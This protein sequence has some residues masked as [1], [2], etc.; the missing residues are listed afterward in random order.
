MDYFISILIRELTRDKFIDLVRQLEGFGTV[1]DQTEK[2]TIIGRSR[3]INI[4]ACFLKLKGQYPEARFGISQYIGLAKGLA[5]IAKFGEILISEEIEQ[6]VIESY[7]ITSLGMLTIEGMKSQILV[8]RIDDPSRDLKYPERAPAEEMIPRKSEVDALKNLLTVT[9]AVLVIAP[10]GSGKTCFLDQFAAAG[11]DR[12]ALR[13]ACPAYM[14]SR[15]LKPVMELVQQML[16]LAELKGIEEKQ[17][18]IEKKLRDLEIR[19]LGTAYLAVLDFLTLSEEESILEK[20]AP[21]T[22]FEIIT[23]SISEILLKISWKAPI[24]IYVEDAE[25]MDA[26]S[27]EFIQVIMQNLAFENIFFIFTSSR[28]QIGISGLKEFEL[29]EIEKR[30]LEEFVEARIGERIA[31]PAVT[32]FHVRQY[33][34]LYDEE[35]TVY[36]FNQYVG[37]TSMVGF[38][39]PF[40]DLRTV[41]K[42][43]LELQENRKEMLYSLAVCG[44]DIDPQ[45]FP[46]DQKDYGQFD[47]FVANNYLKK[48]SQ[49]YAFVSP[50]LHDEIYNL[51]PDKDERHLRFAD[52]YRRMHGYEEY[53]AF[54]YLAGGSSKKAIEFL[55]KSAVLAL[56]QGGYQSS[57][58]YYNQALELCRHQKDS[59]S[60]ETLLALNEGLAD[61]YRALGDEER[62]LKYYKV[63]L[64]SYKEILKE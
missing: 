24:M 58:N 34:L 59:V 15:T 31:L 19:D 9:K 5:R 61:I 42:R 32:P 30:Q 11:S 52:Y 23:N 25:N 39:L 60:M 8:C 55:M 41:I 14:A 46:I 56:K 13:T 28:S 47:F 17:K 63:V 54:H 45:D 4:I 37:E 43:R 35:K 7:Q 6:K 18:A 33:L 53:A 1:I 3:D 36:N 26:A 40:H 57:I 51:V 44:T 38:N 22:R 64:D 48:V 27:L 49:R 20:L 2:D 16:G 10:P 12:I 50:Q 29:R 21:K 62:A